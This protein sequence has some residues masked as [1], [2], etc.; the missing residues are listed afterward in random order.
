MRPCIIVGVV[1]MSVGVLQLT[2]CRTPERTAVPYSV[3]FNVAADANPD[4][5]RKPAPIVLK[6]FQLR[7]ASAFDSADFFSLQDKPESALGGELLGVERVILQPGDSRTLHYSGNVDAHAVGVV[8]EYRLLEKSRWKLSLPL[9]QAKRTSPY[10]FWSGSA[11]EINL[12][13]TV[14]NGGI[15]FGHDTQARP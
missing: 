6:V 2:G 8:A 15:A 14:R 11:D 3:T 4:S 7:A 1:S 10:R 9:P 5:N 13:I 12:P